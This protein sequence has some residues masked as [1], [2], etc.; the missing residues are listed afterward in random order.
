MY[1]KKCGHKNDDNSKF[2]RSCGTPLNTDAQPNFQAQVNQ[3]AQTPQQ[4]TYSQPPVPDNAEQPVYSQPPVYS[5]N[6]SGAVNSVPNTHTDKKLRKMLFSSF[7]LCILGIIL[8]FLT[9]V[10]IPSLKSSFVQS[11]FEFF[12]GEGSLSSFSIFSYGSFVSKYGSKDDIIL[13]NIFMAIVVIAMLFYVAYII[14][15]L[16]KKRCCTAFSMTGSII[17][18][19]MSL[20]YTL[21]FSVGISSSY[22][23]VNL[24]VI[25]FIAI[26]FTIVNIVVT[27]VI[28]ASK[29]KPDSRYFK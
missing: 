19:I 9:W 21:V 15:G 5:Y 12:G 7:A 4:P 17:M 20:L 3:S 2:C 22:I 28:M 24:T 25:P 18:L 8:P 23:K 11:A 6:P 27:C 26:I 16:M 14:F 29:K 13:S 1:C 10:E